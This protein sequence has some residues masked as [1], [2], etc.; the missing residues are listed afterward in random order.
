M[1]SSGTFEL[2]VYE[3]ARSRRGRRP[4]RASRK[5]ASAA[6]WSADSW[7]RRGEL[8]RARFRSRTELLIGDRHDRGDGVAHRDHGRQ[9]DDQH[10][11]Y[12]DEFHALNYDEGV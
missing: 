2:R 10:H 12:N 8:A 4:A 11:D 7:P 6:V 3:A 5:P 1:V 9:R